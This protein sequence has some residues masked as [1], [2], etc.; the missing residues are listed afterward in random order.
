MSGSCCSANT[1]APL[2]EQKPD[3]TRETDR[4][5]LTRLTEKGG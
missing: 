2:D 4:I 5:R 1:R 3:G